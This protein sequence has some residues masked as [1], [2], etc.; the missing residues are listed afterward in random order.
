MRRVTEILRVILIKLLLAMAFVSAANAH[1]MS[2]DRATLNLRDG[3]AYMVLSLVPSAFAD[4]K[5]DDNEDGVISLTEFQA[6]QLQVQQ[7]LAQKVQLKD[8]KGPLVL[9]GLFVNF[10]PAHSPGL[11]QESIVVLAKFALRQ[12]M[13]P[14]DWSIGLWAQP[15]KNNDLKANVTSQ[16]TDGSVLEQQSLVFTPTDHS[17]KLFNKGTYSKTFGFVIGILLVLSM[18]LG[19]IFYRKINGVR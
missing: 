3:G 11:A 1:V 9:E 5:F 10:E 12:G 7:A 8:E 4:I 15:F 19:R 18:V 6:H 2:I 13:M 16:A 14:T 17:Q